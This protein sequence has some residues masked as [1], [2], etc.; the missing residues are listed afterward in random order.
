MQPRGFYGRQREL[1]DL[2][3]IHERYCRWRDHRVTDRPLVQSITHHAKCSH[4]TQ[5]TEAGCLFDSSGISELC[6]SVSRLHNHLLAEQAFHFLPYQDLGT[7]I[8]R[9]AT[10]WEHVQLQD[11]QHGQQLKA[12]V[13]RTI[14]NAQQT[15]QQV[16]AP[17]QFG[18][19]ES[20]RKN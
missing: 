13:R 8:L 17:L 4:I 18:T 15:T 12:I 20:V 7:G 2:G 19:Q 5:Q 3:A 14:T 10:S 1:A 16:Q 11:D 6:Y 9:V